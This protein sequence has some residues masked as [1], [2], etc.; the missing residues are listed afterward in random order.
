MVVVSPLISLMVDQVQ[1][2]RQKGISAAILSSD[3]HKLHRSLL[4][5][6]DELASY[7]HLYCSPE[8]VVGEKWHEICTRPSISQR[9]I[10]I[11]IDEAHCVSKW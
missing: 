4:A 9:L 3:T 11:A 1:E 5:A 8:A 7:S 6:E 10:A 2:L